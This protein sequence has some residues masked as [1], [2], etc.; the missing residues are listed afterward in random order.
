MNNLGINDAKLYGNFIKY[1]FG[2]QITI[3]EV[4]EMCSFGSYIAWQ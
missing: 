1:T 3:I 2:L 4:L